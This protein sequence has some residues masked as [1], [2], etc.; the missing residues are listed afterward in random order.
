MIGTSFADLWEDWL[1]WT[2]GPVDELRAAAINFYPA[3]NVV[4]LDDSLPELCLVRASADTFSTVMVTAVWMHLDEAQRLRGMGAISE[5]LDEGGLLI[6]SL[7]HGPIPT[8][9][10]CLTSP[11]R[12]RSG[13]PK[14]IICNF[15]SMF[16]ATRPSKQTGTWKSPGRGLLSGSA[17]RCGADRARRLP[18]QLRTLISLCQ[19]G[20]N[21][22]PASFFPVKNHECHPTKS[23][24][25]R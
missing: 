14:P 5:L 17:D 3:F 11:P 9:R 21:P 13:L 20:D 15:C 18:A 12:T 16:A 23:R 24:H 4:W 1:Q 19:I 6:M 22:G 8:G 2:T 10:A 25:P 7:R